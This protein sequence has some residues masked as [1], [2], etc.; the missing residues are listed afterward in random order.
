MYCSRFTKLHVVPSHEFRKDSIF[1]IVA[2]IQSTAKDVPFICRT[3]VS[4]LS[5][6]YFQVAVSDTLTIRKW[7]AEVMMLVLRFAG[8]NHAGALKQTTSAQSELRPCTLVDPTADVLEV[9]S[10]RT[11]T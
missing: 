6:V 10:P 5:Y 11:D 4:V 3:C 1:N 8:N 2:V 7:Q 9:C